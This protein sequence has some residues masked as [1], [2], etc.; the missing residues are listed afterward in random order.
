MSASD[1]KVLV[2]ATFTGQ[3]GSQDNAGTIFRDS[4]NLGDATWGMGRTYGANFFGTY[5]FIY[6][7]APGDTSAHTYTPKIYASSGTTYINRFGG[8]GQIVVMEVLA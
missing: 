3:S 5:G 1:S 2:M 7:D 6:L 8:Q 4:T